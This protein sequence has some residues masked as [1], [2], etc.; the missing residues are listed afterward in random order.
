MAAPP[1]HALDEAM[2]SFDALLERLVPGASHEAGIAIEAPPF[3]DGLGLEFRGLISRNTHGFVFRAF[4]PV[5]QREVALKVARP[6]GD[7]DARRALIEEARWC[8]RMQHPAVLAVHEVREHQDLLCVQYTLGPTRTLADVLGAPAELNEIPQRERL[9]V[10]LPVADAIARAHALGGVH[11]HL[12]PGNIGVGATDEPYV[13]DWGALPSRLPNDPLLD[14]SPGHAAPEQFQ[15]ES[16]TPSSDV[17][18]IGVIA[19]ELC[20]LRPLRPRIAGEGLASFVGRW[21]D[22]S[23]EVV[24]L[25]GIH[26]DSVRAVLELALA[27]NPKDRLACGDFLKALEELLSGETERSRRAAEA[28]EYS[29]AAQGALLHLRSLRERIETEER[30]LAA[31]RAESLENISAAHRKRR[32]AAEDRVE[33]LT[34]E[35]G[36]VWLDGLRDATKASVL[37]QSGHGPSA[38]YAEAWAARPAS[39][40]GPFDAMRLG[41][42]HLEGRISLGLDED[43]RAKDARVVVHRVVEQNRRLVPEPLGEWGLPLE[44][45][46][47]PPGRY[48]LTAVARG[49][50]PS[51]YSLHLN[52]REVHASTIR[53]FSR[54]A[55]GEGW[56][57][58][59]AGPYV[60]GGDPHAPA[61]LPRSTPHLGDRFILSLPVTCGEWI[62][63]L[64]QLA[65]PEAKRRRPG[66]PGWRVAGGTWTWRHDGKEWRL[67]TGWHANWPITAI[68]REDANAYARWRSERD[69]RTCRLPTEEEWEKAARGGDGRAWPWGD[70]FDYSFAHC[71]GSSL[72]PS[73]PSKVGSFT[74]DVSVYGVQ[75]MGGNIREW[76]SSEQRDGFAVV[77]G[78]SWTDTSESARCANRAFRP[79]SFRSGFI[80]F[81]LVSDVPLPLTEAPRRKKA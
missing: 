47:L 75:D 7:A 2:S 18:S 31:L 35:Q 56:T 43:S 16:A 21:K 63:F 29:A 74:G 68:G 48:L 44:S 9:R 60:Q 52:P 14:G 3:P 53:V 1:D 32:W 8:A 33:L 11:G 81:R 69:G 49:C 39:I 25:D 41:P 34:I 62:A 19:W 70:R 27:P 28:L 61:S 38:L 51:R 66:D 79:V 6:S 73:T 26:T 17:Y 4:D 78:G 24:Q 37:D 5:L 77:R 58:V 15:G 22:K 12:H 46:A 10:L 13:L 42:Q 59:P 65:L 45:L 72:G 57:F 30:A 50:A 80:G 67:P 36:R 54:A 20:Q 23:A 76:T 71:A 55:I 40:S 64:N